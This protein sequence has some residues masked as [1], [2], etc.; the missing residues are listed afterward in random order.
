[1]EKI[2][3]DYLG[4]EITR[5]CNLK[6]MHCFNGDAQPVDIQPLFLERILSMIGE[7]N[8]LLITGG[9]PA[10]N[11]DGLQKLYDLLI[12]NNIKLHK[13]NITTNGSVN[14][15]QYCGII[16]KLQKYCDRPEESIFGISID[17]YHGN[18]SAEQN[19]I[20]SVSRWLTIRRKTTVKISPQVIEWWGN[21]H[22]KGVGRATSLIP[23]EPWY[24][25]ANSPVFIKNNTISRLFLTAT[26]NLCLDGNIPF[27]EEDHP[28][29]FICNIQD[30]HSIPD[31]FGFILAWNDRKD[32]KTIG[33]LMY[34]GVQIGYRCVGC[35]HADLVYQQ[36]LQIADKI[37]NSAEF[38]SYSAEIKQYVLAKLCWDIRKNDL[39]SKSDTNITS[40]DC[41]WDTFPINRICNL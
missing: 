10:L 1:M 24:I 20:S 38:E 27:V 32:V 36:R 41:P 6:C 7:I 11:I 39:I 35:K 14:V 34:I 18:G 26:G 5:R 4:I 9:E 31:L 13:L 19:Y 40:C 21:K 22:L 15:E 28:C 17:N 3:I 12:Q 29:Y 37:I 33:T 2:R 16:E 8:V 23:A 25:Q 30:V